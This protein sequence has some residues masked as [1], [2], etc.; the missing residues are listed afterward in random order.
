MLVPMVRDFVSMAQ[1]NVGMPF[2]VIEE[3]GEGADPTWAADHTAVHRHRQKFRCR[4]AFTIK[5]VEGIAHVGEPVVRSREPLAACK[6]P[7]VGIE[8]VADHQVLFSV[9]PDPVR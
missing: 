5:A 4:L 7:V 6:A 9:D 2:D 1:P 8:G 3:A